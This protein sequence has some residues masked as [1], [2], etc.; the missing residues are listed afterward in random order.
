MGRFKQFTILTLVQVCLV[1]AAWGQSSKDDLSKYPERID[2]KI[3]FQVECKNA[4]YPSEMYGKNYGECLII[5]GVAPAPTDSKEKTCKDAVTEFNKAAADFDKECGK[6]GLGRCDTATLADCREKEGA[7]EYTNT[8]AL[9]SGF[10]VPSIPDLA[11]K[12]PGMTSSDWDSKNEKLDTKLASAKDKQVEAQ[13]KVVSAQKAY[14]EKNIEL[15]K[16]YNQLN[17]EEAK[18][19]LDNKSAKREALLKNQEAIKKLQ[20]AQ[21]NNSMQV[22]DLRQQIESINIEKTAKLAQASAAIAKFQCSKQTMDALKKMG[23][24]T[25]SDFGSMMQ[26]GSSSRSSSNALYQDCVASFL[27]AR[28]AQIQQ[29]DAKIQALNSRITNGEE[30]QKYLNDTLATTKSQ[31]AEITADM[32]KADQDALKSYTDQVK[33]I[34][35]QMT[36]NYNESTQK[37]AA[38]NANQARLDQ[39]ANRYSNDFLLHQSEKPKAGTTGSYSGPIGVFNT[40]ESARARVQ[41]D[42]NITCDNPT[43]PIDRDPNFCKNKTPFG[44]EGTESDKFGSEKSKATN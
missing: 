19:Q 26:S 17:K 13:E 14:N 25:A 36:N 31:T 23:S 44:Y 1:G 32:E 9:L 37:L 38:L 7:E 4:K 6:S 3:P 34:Q 5:H 12:C 29:F 39:D 8:K 10:G 28:E 15:S 21:F 20:D 35:T 16:A 24:M 33:E 22:Q 42:C 11:R 40:R 27:K 43:R 30:T 2:P 18:R 41:G